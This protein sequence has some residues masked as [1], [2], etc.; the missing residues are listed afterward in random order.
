MPPL[1]RFESRPHPTAPLAY[2]AE[3][4]GRYRTP[5]TVSANAV[6]EFQVGQGAYLAEFGRA[7]RGSVNMVLR[8]GA[9]HFHTD[10]KI[11]RKTV[12]FLPAICSRSRRSRSLS[13][14]VK[15]SPRSLASYTG[16]ISTSV[17]PS[18]GAR[19]SHSTA[20]SIERTCQTQ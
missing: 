7:T 12:Y 2:F 6:E 3:N 9:N 1:G 13:S 8:S 11:G 16:R 19:F 4:R 18:N 20:S 10:A 15:F 17:P 5:S 14:G